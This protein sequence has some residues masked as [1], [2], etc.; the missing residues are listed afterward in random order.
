MKILIT[1]GLGFLGKNLLEALMMAGFK[2]EEI[3]VIDKKEDKNFLKKIGCQFIKADLSVVGEWSKVLR[4]QEL[5]IILQAQISSPKSI[6]FEL[7]NVLATKNI[8]EVAQKYDL[9]K[10][11]YFSSAAVLSLRQD[12]YAKTKKE[13]EEIVKS[14]GLS[15]VI[16]RPSIIYG[17]YDQKNIGWLINFAKKCP[18]FPIPGHGKYPR[19]PVYVGDIS[20]IVIKLI[21]NFPTENKIY[22]INGKETIY[23]REIVKMVL[24][25]MGGIHF[26]ICL[27]L[28]IF[29]FLLRVYDFFFHSPFT[30]DQI[31]SLTSGEVF[32]DYPWWQEFGIRPT[33]FKEGIKKMVA[34]QSY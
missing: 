22:S 21:K 26:A 18:F 12:D 17:P 13:G 32:L 16:L 11:I 6:D 1:G 9:K 34:R 24:G 33:P 28:P 30:P 8:I 5:L 10:V 3:T 23:F 7:H 29:F 25:E 2:M 27:P 19:Q 15:Y 31:K 14:S 20:Q 4:D